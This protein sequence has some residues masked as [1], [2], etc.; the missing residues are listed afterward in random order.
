MTFGFS[1]MTGLLGNITENF[2]FA[3]LA[4]IYIEVIVGLLFGLRKKHEIISIILVN[5]ITN[6]LMNFCILITEPTSNDPNFLQIVFF[7][8]VVI[9]VEWLLLLFALKESPKKLFILSIVMNLLSFGAGYLIT[10]LVASF[11]NLA[12]S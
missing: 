7:E 4:T 8:T 9:L 1:D 3:L 12:T 5:L 6:P 11:I 10:N 2:L